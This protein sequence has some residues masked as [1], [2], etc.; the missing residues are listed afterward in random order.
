MEYPKKLLKLAASGAAKI[1][2]NCSLAPYD[3][4][5]KKVPISKVKIPR[6]GTEEVCPLDKYKVEPKDDPRPWFERPASETEVTDKELFALC[7]TCE[8]RVLL[9]LSRLERRRS[10]G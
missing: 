8:Q 7:A 9:R 2:N 5:R 1:C 4:P 10:S 6:V 3:C